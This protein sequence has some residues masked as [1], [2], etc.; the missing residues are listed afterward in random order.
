ML[1]NLNHPTFP[2]AMKV[3]SQNAI[4]SKIFCSTLTSTIGTPVD[5]NVEKAKD[6]EKQGVILAESGDLEK[7]LNLFNEAI[8]ESPTWASAYNNKAQVLRLLK[9]DE[10][11]PIQD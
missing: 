9:R 10:G 8:N 2:K 3:I 1:T 6:F 7:A 4:E 5:G 11:I